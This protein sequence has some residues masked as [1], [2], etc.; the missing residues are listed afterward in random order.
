MYSQD[1]DD[2]WPTFHTGDSPENARDADEFSLLWDTF[3]TDAALLYCPSTSTK[4]RTGVDTSLGLPIVLDVSYCYIGNGPTGD[5]RLSGAWVAGD[6]WQDGTKGDTPAP[7][8]AMGANMLFGDGH[9]EWKY[10]G[11]CVRLEQSR[12]TV[13]L[14]SL[15][16]DLW[17]DDSTKAI[18]LGPDNT[19]DDIPEKR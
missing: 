13:D 2:Q 12:H 19:I 10:G 7:N 15:D 9:V 1:Y 16:K 5:E 14:D 6:W 3:I 4:V 8:H 18:L 11:E 17:D